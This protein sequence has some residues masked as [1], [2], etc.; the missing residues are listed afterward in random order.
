[1]G[2][3]KACVLQTLLYGSCWMEMVPAQS[4]WRR[5]LG[6]RGELALECGMG[7][8]GSSPKL[9]GWAGL[10]SIVSLSLPSVRPSAEEDALGRGRL[11]CGLLLCRPQERG[12]AIAHCRVPQMR[13]TE[14]GRPFCGNSCRLQG[15]ESSLIADP[16]FSTYWICGAQSGPPAS[17]TWKSKSNLME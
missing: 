14:T 16:E 10:D 12:T 5:G 6:E 3:D 2:R 4:R 7:E 15:R 9:R 11:Q 17:E 13:P 8:G 1:M